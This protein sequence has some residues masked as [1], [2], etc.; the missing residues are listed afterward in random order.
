MWVGSGVPVGSGVALPPHASKAK[1][2]ADTTN[3]SVKR[4]MVFPFHY[5]SLYEADQHALYA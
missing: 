1:A 4:C 5:M 2:V 3:S